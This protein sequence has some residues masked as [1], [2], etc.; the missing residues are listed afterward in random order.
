[1]THINTAQIRAD[2]DEFRIIR[3]ED[4]YALCDALHATRA[5]LDMVKRGNAVALA[6]IKIEEERAEAAEARIAAALALGPEIAADNG[7]WVRWE[8]VER[9]LTG[10]TT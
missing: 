7:G 8:R 10:G 2:M 9:A 4:A 3:M 1:M 5:E 6:G